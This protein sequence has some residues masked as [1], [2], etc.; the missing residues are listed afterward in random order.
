MA[1]V[2]KITYCYYITIK[3]EAKTA[4]SRKLKGLKE[5]TAAVYNQC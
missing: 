3:I 2:S 4:L 5:K 1:G